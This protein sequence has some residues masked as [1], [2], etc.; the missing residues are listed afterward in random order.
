[1]NFDFLNNNPRLA[2]L[3][4]FC[5]DAQTLVYSRPYISG[6][7]SRQALVLCR[8]DFLGYLLH[9]PISVA[10]A[11]LTV[12]SLFFPIISK[13]ISKKAAPTVDTLENTA[14]ED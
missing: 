7:T 11:I 2:K 12:F 8:G 5:N 9:R 4:R 13:A 14:Q 3:A 6:F 10:L 1:M